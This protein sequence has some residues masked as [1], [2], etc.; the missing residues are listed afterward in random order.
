MRRYFCYLCFLVPVIGC[1]PKATDQNQSSTHEPASVPAPA[2]S[3]TSTKQADVLQKD[4]LNALQD[5][6]TRKPSANGQDD[7]KAFF[8]KFEQIIQRQDAAAFNQLISKEHGLYIID[9]PGAMPQFNYIT[10]IRTFK[11][12]NVEQSPFFSIRETFKNC[13][14]QTVKALP[15]VNCEGDVEPYEKK[16]CFVADGSAFQKNDAYKYAS[17]PAEQ[18]KTVAQT[19]KLVTKTVLHTTSGFKFHFGQ[20]NGQWRVLFIDLMIPCSA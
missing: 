6:V 10:D 2:T 5:E 3:E 17:L 19:Q 4:T 9:T 1:Q 7:F 14:L 12:A 16:G 18:E 13:T 8:Q 15:K 20:V 11:R